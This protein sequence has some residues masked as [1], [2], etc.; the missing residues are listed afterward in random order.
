MCGPPACVFADFSDVTFLVA[1]VTHLF[2]ESA[3]LIAVVPTTTA[4]AVTIVLLP[5]S[6][7]VCITDRVN[8]LRLF[9]S[10]NGC[11]TTA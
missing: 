9:T 8:T 10:T 11:K 6:A 4:I 5:V 2:H 3:I 7:S 1:V